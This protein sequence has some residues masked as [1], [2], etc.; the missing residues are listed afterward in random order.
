MPNNCSNGELRLVGGSSPNEGRVELC[1]H[2]HWG[3]VCSDTWD[4]RDAAVVCREV[5]F[6][7]E[8]E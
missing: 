7:S 4:D 6:Q 1:F 8:G 5:G 2:G 3:T